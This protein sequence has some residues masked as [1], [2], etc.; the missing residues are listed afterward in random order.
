MLCS[1]GRLSLP[2][3]L[4]LRTHSSEGFAPTA[5]RQKGKLLLLVLSKTDNIETKG[6]GAVGVRTLDTWKVLKVC[7]IKGI[8]PS[9]AVSQHGG[10][11]L[12]IEDLTAGDGMLAKKR[13]PTVNHI[14]WY[15]QQCQAGERSQLLDFGECFIYCKRGADSA[16]IGNHRIKLGQHLGA[17]T[18]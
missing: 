2:R 1:L 14:Q 11:E 18:E 9:N 4:L 5:S 17:Q 3:S 8:E 16:R 13:D 7:S 6:Y 10:D 12:G 15:R